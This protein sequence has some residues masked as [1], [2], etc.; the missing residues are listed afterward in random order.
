M[1]G[2]AGVMFLG[3]LKNNNIKLSAIKVSLYNLI[4]FVPTLFASLGGLY[5]SFLII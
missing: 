3:T 4:I 1:N 5:L 2:L